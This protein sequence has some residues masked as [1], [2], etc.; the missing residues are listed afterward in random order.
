[1]W[2]RE[3]SLEMDPD[4]WFQGHFEASGWVPQFWHPHELEILKQGLE[5]SHLKGMPFEC[6]LHYITKHQ[7]LGRGRPDGVPGFLMFDPPKMDG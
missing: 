5:S 7:P 4:Q 6:R 2:Y 1:M 3:G